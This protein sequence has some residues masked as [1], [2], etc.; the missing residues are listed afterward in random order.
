MIS[1]KLLFAMIAAFVLQFIIPGF[2]EL[3]IFDPFLVLTQPWRLVTSIFLHNTQTISHIFFNG[4]ALF[5]F[6][7]I[8]ERRLTQKE[9]LILFFGAGLIGSLL[10]YASI[11]AEIIHR[12]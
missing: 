1:Q 12:L 7:Q 9:F 10:F 3:F 6:G 11:L 4:Y 2:T 8:L 5:M